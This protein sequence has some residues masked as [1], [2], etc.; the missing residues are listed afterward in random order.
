[1]QTAA[2]LW[3]VQ[4]DPG[5]MNQV[6]MNLCLNARDAMPE[7]G[8]LLLETANVVLDD[9]YA[10]QHLDARPGEFVRLRV[11]DTGHGIPPEIRPRIFEPFFTTKEPGKGTGLGLAMVFG[12]V[13]QHQGW[14]EC[15][16][17]VGQGTALRH[18]PAALAGRR[19]GGR[20][21]R[22]AAAPPAAAARPS[23]WSTTRR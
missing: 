19:A 15:H 8:R 16:S 21:G 9:E 14:I 12:I 4:A 11:S 18:L 13:K 2:D 17:E 10:R 5:Q 6:L 20:A 3:T 7:G 22:R 1:M 23:C